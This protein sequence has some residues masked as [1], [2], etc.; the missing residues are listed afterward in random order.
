MN[1]LLES[2]GMT[3]KR[4]KKATGKV[5]TEIIISSPVTSYTCRFK[6][7]GYNPYSAKRGVKSIICE[8]TSLGQDNLFVIVLGQER[9]LSRLLRFRNREYNNFKELVAF[10][11][12]SGLSTMVIGS[13]RITKEELD[14][15]LD[16]Y[17]AIV[18]SSR[19]QI[20]YLEELATEHED[21]LVF[22]GALGFQDDIRP[23][24][25]RLITALNRCSIEISILSGDDRDNCLNVANGI[26]KKKIDFS[27]TTSFYQ[28]G[29]AQSTALTEVMT[30]IL[31]EI[32]DLIKKV[33]KGEIDK[34]NTDRLDMGGKGGQKGT[35]EDTPT[36]HFEHD[37]HS[38][39]AFRALAN[40]SK[41]FRKTL[42]IQGSTVETIMHS[43]ELAP[44]LEIILLFCNSVIGYSL[45]PV[46][47]SFLVTQLKRK[48]RTVMTIGDGFN[49]IGMSIEAHVGVQL[50]SPEVPLLF[51]DITVKDLDCLHRLLFLDG[52]YI[53]RNLMMAVFLL[54]WANLNKLTLKFVF[55]RISA[56][57]DDVFREVLKRSLLSNVLLTLVLALRFT[58]YSRELLKRCTNF[59]R[60][61]ILIGL[62]QYILLIY[63]V[64]AAFLESSVIALAF[65]MMLSKSLGQELPVPNTLES[66]K[67]L[68]MLTCSIT[69]TFKVFLYF[70]GRST[71]SCIVLGL[72]CLVYANL[73][74]VILAP[75]TH[76]E[77]QGY[78]PMLFTSP[79]YDLMLLLCINSLLCLFNWLFSLFLNA[80]YFYPFSSVFRV[81]TLEG[82]YDRRKKEPRLTWRKTA[83]K[84]RM[85]ILA[86]YKREMM[87][88]NLVDRISR[89]KNNIQF[90]T[91]VLSKILWIDLPSYTAGINKYTLQIKEMVERRKFKL[92]QWQKMSWT[93]QINFGMSAGAS[94]IAWAV[95]M[96]SFP[97]VGFYML[98]TLLPATFLFSLACLALVRTPRFQRVFRTVLVVAGCVA[99]LAEVL[100]VLLCNNPLQY[101]LVDLHSLRIWHNLPLDF[102][103]SFIIMSVSATIRFTA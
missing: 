64:L 87:V 59:Y 4:I 44:M 97:D 65:E 63:I 38:D 37:E 3:V 58:P 5:P 51:S 8:D 23:D 40:E 9:H 28:L 76:L 102:L 24:A 11:K 31:E 69:S 26:R 70:R 90:V 86:V 36:A 71:Q 20:E 103:T 93:P 94:A 80:K 46:H 2:A 41:E 7:H 1:E 33:N 16:K 82:S 39:Q 25:L 47:K 61:P 95:S 27:D 60:E 73:E 78:F 57:R 56:L 43:K 88:F 54:T 52:S 45:Q 89:F 50:T 74:Y 83:D 72:L 34:A 91:P 53:Y 96:V 49:D 101:T 85:L 17:Q 62:N 42:V 48:G 55:F 92:N 30:R 35:G 98:D 99:V 81:Q 10:N 19:D 32:Y 84:I 100:F 79:S 66:T 22:V 6:V 12:S 29:T 15:Y 21:S 14:L 68:L 75:R 67:H 77:S 18:K 13:K